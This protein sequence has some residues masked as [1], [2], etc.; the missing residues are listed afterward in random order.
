MKT[1]NRLFSFFLVIVFL[2]SATF[3]VSA[4]GETKGTSV[5]ESEILTFYE[6]VDGGGEIVPMGTI[7]SANLRITKTHVPYYL[8]GV[9]SRIVVTVTWEWLNYTSNYL[10]DSIF[11]S[12]D[13]SQVDWRFESSS[14]SRKHY[15]KNGLQTSWVLRST[16]YSVRDTYPN[17]FAYDESLIEDGFGGSSIST[18]NKGTITF[19]VKPITST[20]GKNHNFYL[21]VNYEHKVFAVLGFQASVS[22]GTLL[23]TGTF[24]PAFGVGIGTKYDGMGTAFACAY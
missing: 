15:T 10:E 11:F 2:L 14:I 17:G 8:N 4:K 7:S 18:L 23:A 3:T 13:S 24:N 5:T 16:E 12:W 22:F 6:S 21:Y 1:F 9:V 19:T 20:V